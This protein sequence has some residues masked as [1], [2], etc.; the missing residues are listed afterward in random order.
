VMR[1]IVAPSFV[2][3]PLESVLAASAGETKLWQRPRLWRR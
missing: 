1:F 3:L 2:P